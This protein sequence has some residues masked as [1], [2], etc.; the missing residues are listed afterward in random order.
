MYFYVKKP[1]KVN[2]K[3]FIPAVC[4]E[5]TT[6]NQREAEILFEANLAIKSVSYIVFQNGKP[7]AKKT[8][9]KKGGT[10]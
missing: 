1:I 8:S 2:G 6:E 3:R 5:V 4:Y 7:V 10:K 9:R